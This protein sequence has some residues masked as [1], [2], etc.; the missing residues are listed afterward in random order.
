[1]TLY[2]FLLHTIKK[3]WLLKTSVTFFMQY[4]TRK[5][6]LTFKGIVEQ[7][8]GDTMQSSQAELAQHNLEIMGNSC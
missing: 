8:S 4:P 2:K 3:T 7:K 1:M 5:E 6:N